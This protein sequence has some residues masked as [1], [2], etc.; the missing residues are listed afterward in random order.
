M[1]PRL[2]GTKKRGNAAV[3]ASARRADLA[4]DGTGDAGA[5][6]P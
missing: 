4:D 2:S 5:R 1:A 6:S 3:P